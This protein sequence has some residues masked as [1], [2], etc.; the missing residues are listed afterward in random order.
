ML[1]RHNNNHFFFLMLF[2]GDASINW[3]AFVHMNFFSRPF[4]RRIQPAASHST[5]KLGWLQWRSPCQSQSDHEVW[6]PS[7]RNFQVSETCL[8]HPI[9]SLTRQVIFP[10]IQFFSFRFKSCFVTCFYYLTALLRTIR[11]QRAILEELV[12][13]AHFPFSRCTVRAYVWG[14]AAKRL[15]G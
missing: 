6:H 7:M 10:K 4:V 9:I 5:Q 1:I 3:L 13:K 2:I 11:S 14:K 8:L 15:F 12:C